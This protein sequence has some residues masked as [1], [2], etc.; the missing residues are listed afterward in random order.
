MSAPFAREV[1]AGLLLESGCVLF[2]VEHPF[3]YASGILS[4]IYTDCRRVISEPKLRGQI[5][6]M[7]RE[8]LEA[9]EASGAP[10]TLVA[11]VAT[12]GIPHATLLADRTG[13]PLVYVRGEAKEHG[14]RRLIEGNLPQEARA[15]LIE[16]VISTGRSALSAART[17]RNAGVEVG[18][19]L[20]IMSYEFKTTVAEFEATALPRASLTD[21]Q[22]L[23]E[24]ASRSEILNAGQRKEV[25]R[26][27]QDVNP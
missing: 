25:L 21:F 8:A 12:A 20:S 9:R 4:P 14:T 19:C 11:G 22:T 13:L 10:F 16:D 24:V 18:L 27:W 3:R 1:V 17:L 23:V 7:L 26:W 15:V 2:N 5:A 6:D